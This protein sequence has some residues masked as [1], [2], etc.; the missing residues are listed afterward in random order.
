MRKNTAIDLRNEL[1][2]LQNELSYDILYNRAT[3]FLRCQCYDKRYHSGD[4]KC[5]ICHGS[6]F[7]TTLE[8]MKVIE[9]TPSIGSTGSKTE[10]F[11]FGEFNQQQKIFY[12]TYKS[13]PQEKDYIF[14]TGWNKD[15]TPSGVTSVYVIKAVNAV[16]GDHGRLEYY[17]VVAALVPDMKRLVRETVNRLPGSGKR[18]IAEGKRYAWPMENSPKRK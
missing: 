16:R 3:K 9:Y 7:V 8:R 12:L 15:K 2:L 5:P 1:D 13:A 14:V 6:G 11:S 4:S 10:M 17:K 18:A